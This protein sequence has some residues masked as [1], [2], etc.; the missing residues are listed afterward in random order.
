MKNRWK[1]RILPVREL[2]DIRSQVER[3]VLFVLN[4]AFVGYRD[5]SEYE[6]AKRRGASGALGHFK[7]THEL[8]FEGEGERLSS[9]ATTRSARKRGSSSGT[10]GT[11]STRL[12]YHNEEAQLSARK[13]TPSIPKTLR[14][15]GR[16]R[17]ASTWTP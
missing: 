1:D 15:G 11:R 14:C 9:R 4:T 7:A 10:L 5:W 8:N 3:L 6:Y 13:S 17:E 16:A 2:K 12:R